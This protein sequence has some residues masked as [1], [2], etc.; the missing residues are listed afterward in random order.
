MHCT[1]CG[2]EV[3]ADAEFCAGCGNRVQ[4]AAPLP[5][6]K[7]SGWKWALGILAVL[8]ILGGLVSEPDEPKGA[9]PEPAGV[10]VSLTVR[11]SVQNGSIFI[12]GNTDLPDGAI[13]HCEVKSEQFNPP[14]ALEKEVMIDLEKIEVSGGSF[15]AKADASDFAQGKASIYC[16]FFPGLNPQPPHVNE[17]YGANGE[18]LVG[19]NVLR[20]SD[21]MPAQVEVK[22][23]FEF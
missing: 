20:L 19:S 8:A 17:K 6:R 3:P 16:T 10:T 4:A 1:N 22:E 11:P 15:N 12:S 21:S 5:T 9:K 13:V 7:R 18:K 14:P 23:F 2:K